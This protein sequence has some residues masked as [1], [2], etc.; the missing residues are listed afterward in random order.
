MKVSQKN[1]N[2]VLNKD[3][4]FTRECKFY[5][6]STHLLTLL[7]WVILGPRTIDSNHSERT[8]QIENFLQTITQFIQQNIKLS[9]RP[10]VILNAAAQQGILKLKPP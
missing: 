8:P 10:N 3:W 9:E 6:L 7:K 4:E 5:N 1:P 2:E